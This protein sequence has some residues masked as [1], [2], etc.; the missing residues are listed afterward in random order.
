MN[1]IA[2][3]DTLDYDYSTYWKNREYENLSER[4][5]LERVLKDSKGKWFIDIGGSY[6][7]LADSYY[8]R[9][10]NPVIV[11]Y[12]LKTLQK[13]YKYLKDRYPNIE[14]IAANAYN[15]PFRNNIFDGGVM[16]RVLH[17]IDRPVEYFKE[18]KRVLSSNAIY[19][20]EF[21]NK[22]HLKA[23]IRAVLRLDFSVFNREPYQQ[24]TKKNY[25]GARKGSNVPFFNYHTAWIK[26]SLEREGFKIE[27]K[28][29]CSFL[30]VN[31]LKRI[32]N[33]K[34]LLFFENILQITF[35]WSN[36]SPSIF[37]KSTI[38]K[39]DDVQSSTT[40]QSIL[41]CPK[42]KASLKIDGVKAVCTKC[43]NI[44]SK[45]KN[46]WDFRI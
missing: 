30:R 40:L 32:F 1:K 15:L 11:D 12:S 34:I 35:S 4:L 2:D 5:V 18:L 36:I 37:L 16:V 25:E 33:T 43:K 6:G 3:Y 17:H 45:E 38:K 22:A 31:T 20:Q 42:C 41:V 9:Y 23:L 19:I 21:A 8:N 27:K 13:N 29:G 24:P 7:R 46:I 14:L 39:D 28:Y 26:D 10:T 44:Y